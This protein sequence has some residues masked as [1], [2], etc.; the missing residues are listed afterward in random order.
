MSGKRIEISQV[1][2]YMRSREV[3]LTQAEAAYV[4]EFSE[5]SG[6]SIEAGDYQPNRG[7]LRDWST[8]ADPLAAVWESELEPMLKRAPGLKPM[9][10]FEYLQAKYPGKYGQVL[11][12]VQRRVAAWKAL[13][14]PA[15]EVM[16][17][18]RHEPGMLGFSDFTELKGLVI[19][20]NGKPLEH[21]LYPYR[22]GY[23]GWQYAQIIQ[24]GE[25]F[26]PSLKVCRMLYLP[27]VVC[28][29]SIALIV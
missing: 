16:F 22:L 1:R 6:Q 7:K 28:L 20:I 27:A 11:R 21:L 2:V 17:G 23:S 10:L 5:R 19:T 9:T 12:T 18:L 15:P 29:S 14:G 25:S 26:M 3:G 4:A 24:G 8:C 13:Y